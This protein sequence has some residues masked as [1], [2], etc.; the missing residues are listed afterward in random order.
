M[1]LLAEWKGLGKGIK[2]PMMVLLVV[3]ASIV[4]VRLAFWVDD[5]RLGLRRRRTKNSGLKPLR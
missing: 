5:P 3:I 1:A 4:F 2:F